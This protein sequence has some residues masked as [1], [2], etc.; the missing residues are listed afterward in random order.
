MEEKEK[1]EKKEKAE[2]TEREEVVQEP[3]ELEKVQAQADD[4][5]RKWYAVTA[6]YDNYRKRT[7]DISSQKYAEGRADVILKILPVGDDIDR[8][9]AVCTDEKM[10][11]G[12]EMV[13]ASFDKTV[14]EEGIE[15]FDPTGE[16]FD[17]T[18]SAAIAALPPAEGEASGIVKQTFLKGYRKGDKILR[19]AQVIVTQ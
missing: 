15:C 12:L 3:S 11:Q 18:T 19:Y 14:A 7:K 10:K 9:L 8:A 5:K 16:E 17:S 1:K 13:K 2:E 4:F 6:E